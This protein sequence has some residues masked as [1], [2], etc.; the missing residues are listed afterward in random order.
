MEQ[1]VAAVLDETRQQFNHDARFDLNSQKGTAPA[2]S[3]ASAGDRLVIIQ[4]DKLV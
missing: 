3:A 2:E 1:I 4:R